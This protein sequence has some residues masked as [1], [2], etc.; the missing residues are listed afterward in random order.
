MAAKALKAACFS[1]LPQSTFCD[2]AF[3]IADGYLTD[4]DNICPL[5]L[6]ADLL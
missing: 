4:K 5:M 6:L 2:K 3:Y 1:K